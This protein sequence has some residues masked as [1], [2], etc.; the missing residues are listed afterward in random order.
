MK[1]RVVDWGYAAGWRVVRSVPDA[2]ARRAFDGLADLALRRGGPTSR[3]LARNLARVVGGP[4][5]P[6]LLHAAMRS[7]ARYWREAFRLPSVDHAA[8][9]E[10]IDRGTRGAEHV[11]EAHERGRGVVFALPHMG[12]WDAAAVWLIH[13]GVPFTTVAERLRPESLYRRFV[14]YREDLGMEVLPLTGGARPPAA[15]LADRLRAGGAVCLLGDRDLTR[16]GVEVTFFGEPALMPPGPALLAATTGATLVPVSLW[17]DG[18]GWGQ[19]I[20]APIPVAARERLRDRVAQTTQSLA[21]W[22]A[23]EIA[24]HPTDWHMVQRLWLA[25]LDPDRVAG[26]ARPAGG[27]VRA[28]SDRWD[29]A[30]G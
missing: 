9:V 10:L 24:A 12:N 2:V 15:V 13:N 28:V 30:G 8:M 27:V 16:S 20:G 26:T 3:Q 14:S 19:R 5:P 1:D 21:D 4:P 22:F 18:A 11:R 17:F 7:Y 6:S 23:V 29:G 25:D